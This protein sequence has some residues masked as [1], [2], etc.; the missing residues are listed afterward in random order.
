MAR[1]R[2]G[3]NVYEEPMLRLY[4]FASSNYHNIVK[5]VLIEKGLEFEEITTYPPAD[6]AYRSR[7]PTGK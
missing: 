5:L 7:N 2:A 6:D 1:R 3:I 4:G